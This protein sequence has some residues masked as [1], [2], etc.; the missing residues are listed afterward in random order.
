MD[1]NPGDSRRDVQRR[2]EEL[3]PLAIATIAE[4][5]READQRSRERAARDVLRYYGWHPEVTDELVDQA[6][7]VLGVENARAYVEQ[8]LRR[9][10]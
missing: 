5:M 10:G 8:L 3:I 7:E 9:D 6:I 4:A 1:T 2:I